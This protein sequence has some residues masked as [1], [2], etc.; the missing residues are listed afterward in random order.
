MKYYTL[1]KIKCDNEGVNFSVCF[2][3]EENFEK[4][5]FMWAN[6]NDCCCAKETIDGFSK[7]ARD[8]Q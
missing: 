4:F 3:R 1:V 6:Q 8:V 5:R 7:T 2:D